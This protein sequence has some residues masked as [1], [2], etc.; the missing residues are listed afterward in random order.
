[1]MKMIQIAHVGEKNFEKRLLFMNLKKKFTQKFKVI[2]SIF[3]HHLALLG[4]YSLTP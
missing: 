2:M 3:N 1:M 4:K